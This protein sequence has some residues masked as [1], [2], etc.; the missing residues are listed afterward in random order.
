MNSFNQIYSI[1]WKPA[2]AFNEAKEQVVVEREALAARDLL[3][4]PVSEPMEG[5]IREW[6][7]IKDPDSLNM[8]IE[9]VFQR[10]DVNGDK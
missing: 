6:A 4:A 2:E 3:T 1:E 5:L 9:S 10:M 8:A 7:R